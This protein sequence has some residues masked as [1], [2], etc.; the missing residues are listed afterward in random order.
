MPHY[1]TVISDDGF[2]KYYEMTIQTWSI[3]KR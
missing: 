1:P 3:S 2:I